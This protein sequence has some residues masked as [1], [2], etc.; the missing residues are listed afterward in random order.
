MKIALVTT[1]INVPEVL[2]LYR[3][4]GPQVQIFVA[5]DLKT[6]PEC[7]NLCSEIGA[8][9]CLP[10]HDDKAWKCSELIGRNTI[11]RRNVAILEALRWGADVIISI[12]DDN[13]PLDVHYFDDFS[14][15]FIPGV[16][17][18]RGLQAGSDGCWFDYGRW[19]FPRDGID[20]VCQ[21]GIPQPL[22][23]YDT[24][25]FATDVRIGAAQG[26]CLGDPDTSAID[27][28]SRLPVVHQLSELLRAGIVVNPE[29]RTVFNTQTT[30]FCRDLAPCM[31]LCP[32]FGRNDDIYASLICRRVMRETGHYLHL[33]RP[34][35]WQKR[36]AHNLLTDLKKEIWG[37]SH[38]VEFANWL[39]E[40]GF[41][42]VSV[43][44]MVRTIYSKMNML[45][46]MPP[47]VS[48]LGLAWC[49][50]VAGVI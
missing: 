32:Q 28:L 39:D 4:H 41:H 24:V 19:Q 9:I 50:D 8:R 26:I 20:P 49:N 21:R 27:R 25:S 34:F 7:A 3:A 47:G 40:F 29:A 38:V 44:E 12:D 42:N 36:N 35:V 45:D 33:G 11:G 30:A 6:P 1:T 43:L 13:A 10:E 2:R 14:K 23:S 37:M 5:V 18:W 31:L 48:E 17:Y 16:A 15:L 46:W 22:I